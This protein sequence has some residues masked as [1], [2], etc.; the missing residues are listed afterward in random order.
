M[1]TAIGKAQL[2]PGERLKLTD[3]LRTIA[4]GGADG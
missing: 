4:T 2:A 1:V 3:T